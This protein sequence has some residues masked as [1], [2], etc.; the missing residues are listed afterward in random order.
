MME[1]GMMMQ[2][3]EPMMSGMMLAAGVLWVLL[4]AVLALAAL[5]SSSICARSERNPGDDVRAIQTGFI[6]L[7]LTT[8]SERIET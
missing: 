1:R 7:R 3:H 4:V 2:M 6:R 5:P 8:I